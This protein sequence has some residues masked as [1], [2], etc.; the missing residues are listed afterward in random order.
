MELFNIKIRYHSWGQLIVNTNRKNSR[1]Y[2]F[3][4]MEERLNLK[5]FGCVMKGKNKANKNKAGEEKRKDE[6]GE[7]EK[8]EMKKHQRELE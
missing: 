5:K 2:K 6:K 8:Q 1:F 3:E 4:R 7:K